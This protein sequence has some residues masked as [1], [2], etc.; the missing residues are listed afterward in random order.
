MALVRRLALILLIVAGTVGCDQLSKSAA[1]DHLQGQATQRYLGDVFRLQYAENRGAFLG[2]GKS[3]SKPVRRAIFT[4]GAI[5]MVAAV[6][7]YAL[8]SSSVSRAELISLALIGAGG[9]GNIIDRVRFD[10]SVTDFMNLGIGS[11]RTGI[12]NVADVALMV[13]LALMLLTAW[14][15]TRQAPP[16]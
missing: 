15:D 9:A 3:L 2:L 12:F 4:G 11:I 7:L 16:P 6:L 1:R 13:G 10:G 8:L 14:R 5:L